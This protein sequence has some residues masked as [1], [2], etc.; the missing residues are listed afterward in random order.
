MPKLTLPAAAARQGDHTEHGGEITAGSENVSINGR[1][2]A[3]LNHYHACPMVAEGREHVGGRIRTASTY[4]KI[5]GEGAARVGDELVCVGVPTE[6]PDTCE[7]ETGAEVGFE[8]NKSDG[9]RETKSTMKLVDVS[10]SCSAYSLEGSV[11]G[12]LGTGTGS[13][14]VGAAQANAQVGASYD[15]TKNQGFAGA[16][17]SAGSA[18]LKGSLGGET[19]PLP[20][21]WTG[22]G[23]SL[24]GEVTG[25]LISAEIGLGAFATYDK[26]GVKFSV[27]EKAGAGVGQSVKLGLAAKPLKKEE[28]MLPPFIDHIC[29]G[30]PDVFIGD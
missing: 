22:W 24:T 11:E 28:E 3:R 14:E 8:S 10:W 29:E 26:K 18:L 19:P 25:S 23:I 13:V 9:E 16:N 15:R 20:I 6:K 12:A 4:V 5:N 27:F 30:S 7:V 1:L 21:P 17:V 2:A